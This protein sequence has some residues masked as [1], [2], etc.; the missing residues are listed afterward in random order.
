MMALYS[1][2]TVR[3]TPSPASRPFGFWIEVGHDLRVGVFGVFGGVPE[4]S[5]RAASDDPDLDSRFLF[6]ACLLVRSQ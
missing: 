2:T 3:R 5:D 6:L 1:S 4:L